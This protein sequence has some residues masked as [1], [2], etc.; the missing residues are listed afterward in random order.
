[1]DFLHKSQEIPDPRSKEKVALLPEGLRPIREVRCLAP[2]LVSPDPQAKDLPPSDFAAGMSRTLSGKKWGEFTGFT[3]P[4]VGISLISPSKT[5]DF[6][7]K[8]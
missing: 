4:K 1:M 8:M 5:R 7:R 6:S 3:R 2:L